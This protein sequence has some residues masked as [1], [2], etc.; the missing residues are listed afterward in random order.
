MLFNKSQNGQEEL[1]ALLGFLH[2]SN[3]FANIETDIMLEHE[4]MTELI[5]KPVMDKAQAHYITANYNTG[6]EYK[7]L[8][9]L[10]H[11][12]QLPIA[13][14]ATHNY[15]AHND[16]GHGD[17]GRKVKIDTANEKMAWE[18][19]IIRDDE[20]TL[21]K[22]HKTTDRLISFLDYN[23]DSITEWKD[24][25]AQKLARSLFINTAKQ[26]GDIFP[27]DN[28]RRFFIKI[29]PFIRESERKYLLPV[30]GKTRFD[31]V[32]T[33]IKSGDFTDLEDMLMLIRVPLV[34]YTLSLAVKRLSVSILPNG[35]FQEYISNNQTLKAKQPAPTDVRKEV[36]HSFLADAQ[37]ELENLQKEL[38]KLDA[39]AAAID[40]VPEDPIKHIDPESSIFR[41]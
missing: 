41:I 36:G 20:A 27:I 15:A 35:I 22:A 9:D 34:Y 8:D 24:S 23:A 29:M 39:E 4:A 37:L 25:D 5:G 6:G 7:L 11:Y 10:V 21:N 16:V 26:F 40:Y 33:A 38:T 2:A 18:W 12:I 30:L 17:D 13:Y 1:K 31:D 32:K 3:K 14:Y 19:M 28:S